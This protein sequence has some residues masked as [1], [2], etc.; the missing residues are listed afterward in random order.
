M[1]NN[2]II[3]FSLYGNN[4]LYNTGALENAHLALDI[5]PNWVCYFYFRN[6]CNSKVLNKLSKLK[7]VKLISMENSKI[8]PMMWRFIPIFNSKKIII[9][10]DTDSRLNIKEKLALIFQKKME[11]MGFM[12]LKNLRTKKKQKFLLKMKQKS[13]KTERKNPE[14]CAPRVLILFNF[15]I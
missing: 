15:C 8:I 13:I 2:K 12:L 7:N 1:N 14:T 3:S 4:N 5:Y 11:M 10:R 9:V 6:D